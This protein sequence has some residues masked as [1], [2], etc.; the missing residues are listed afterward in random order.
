MVYLPNEVE[1]MDPVTNLGLL[2][3]AGF[4]SAKICADFPCELGIALKG[5]L[6]EAS[7]DSL[8]EALV[9]LA[10]VPLKTGRLFNDGQILEN[11]S[12]PGFPRFTM[13][14][15]VDWDPM[16]GFRFLAPH[17]GTAFLRVVPLFPAEA[18]FVES[19]TDRKKGYCALVNRGMV[20]QDPDR[21][22]VV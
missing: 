6:G 12:L 9:E 18:D 21:G 19:R 4:S 10:S 3:T 2:G 13:A 1:Q 17:A 15:L 11:I 22:P 16:D 7:V 14:L 20:D 5:P 8:A